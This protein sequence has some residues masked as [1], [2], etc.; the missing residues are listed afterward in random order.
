MEPLMPSPALRRRT[1]ALLL[2]TALAASW[3][4]A[5]PQA[6]TAPRATKPATA[7]HQD[8]LSRQS[9]VSAAFGIIYAA[10]STHWM[11]SRSTL[12]P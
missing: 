10:S 7:V 3:A 9:Q 8:L 12:L 2:A 4:A 11:T 1:L 6:T 5:G